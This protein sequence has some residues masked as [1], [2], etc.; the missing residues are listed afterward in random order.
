MKV[1][2]LD[3]DS[4]ERD[5]NVYPYSN[6]YT[7]TLNNPIYNVTNI[8]LVSARIPTPQLTTC[9]TNKSFSVDGV[10]ISL[11]ETNY[12]NGEVLANDLD[13]KLQPPISNV[14]AV[15]FDSDT[16]AL[17]FSNTTSGGNFTFEFF[18]GTQGYSSNIA[19]TTPHQVM[20]F[21]SQNQSSSNYTLTSGAINLGG[22]NSLIM[23]LTSGSD[24][25]TQSVYSR[26]PFYTGHILLNGSDVINY[27]GTDD[28]LKHEFYSGPQKYI[29]T[30]HIEFFYMS[31][32]R[33][34]PYDFRHQDHI[35]K[36]EITGSTDKLE[37]LPKVPI[38]EEEGEE[39]AP[40]I[41][42]PGDE[43]N[44]YKWKEYLSIGIIVLVGII[45]MSLVRRKPKLS[46]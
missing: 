27:H 16:D 5:T 23:K 8:T 36:F 39:D 34:I 7:V 10:T 1:H 21:S 4:G 43:V 24:E 40:S 33:L 6:S 38:P 35:L 15:V 3:I 44:A 32:G 29:S 18:D 25:F 45:L 22:P 13:I 14:D 12:S 2:T 41:S 11:D 17:T 37:G 19:L 9:A 30:I 28:P 20:G 31:H 46:E 26:T 42:I